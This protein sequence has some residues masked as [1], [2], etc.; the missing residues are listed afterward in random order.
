MFITWGAARAMD[1]QKEPISIPERSLTSS[2]VADID[3]ASEGSKSA[4]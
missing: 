2:A 3:V 4:T 1:V